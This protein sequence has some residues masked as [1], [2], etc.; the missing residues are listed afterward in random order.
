[1]NKQRRITS[2]GY[3]IVDRIFIF[4]DLLVLGKN[5]SIVLEQGHE[6]M[7]F[8]V[9]IKTKGEGECTRNLIAKVNMLNNSTHSSYFSRGSFIMIKESE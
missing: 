6:D 9:P 1:M 5:V 7:P 2:T 3:P 4:I 8:Y